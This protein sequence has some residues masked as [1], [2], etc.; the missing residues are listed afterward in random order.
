ML[1]SCQ[2]CGLEEMEVCYFSFTDGG[3]YWQNSFGLLQ[4]KTG[5]TTAAKLNFSFFII[6]TSN[7]KGFIG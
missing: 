1:D 7:H 2:C 3:V 4:E 5:M 6:I